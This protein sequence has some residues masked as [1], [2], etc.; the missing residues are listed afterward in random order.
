[1]PALQFFS[2]EADDAKW[3]IWGKIL[4]RKGTRGTRYPEPYVRVQITETAIRVS[5]DLQTFYYAGAISSACQCRTLS[6]VGPESDGTT[7]VV[8]SDGTVLASIVGQTGAGLANIN[9]PA[10]TTWTGDGWVQLFDSPPSEAYWTTGERLTFEVPADVCRPALPDQA[11]AYPGS[12]ERIGYTY[13]PAE[14]HTADYTTFDIRQYAN[15]ED[16]EDWTLVASGV[17][18]REVSIVFIDGVQHQR[19]VLTYT[20]CPL[21]LNDD[22]LDGPTTDVY[23]GYI[24]YIDAAI[25]ENT[26][27]ATP[28]TLAVSGSYT[29]GE[30]D[31][32]G[33]VQWALDWDAARV[34]ANLRERA[35]LKACS[36]A[37]TTAMLE[38]GVLSSV[39]T[40]MHDA[41]PVAFRPVEEFTEAEMREFTIIAFG[42]ASMAE[43]LSALEYGSESE[44]LA[45]YSVATF[46]ALYLQE[47]GSGV[48]RETFKGGESIA[49]F[50]LSIVHSVFGDLGMF[51]QVSDLADASLL[52]FHAVT[53]AVYSYNVQTAVWSGRGVVIADAEGNSAPISVPYQVGVNLVFRSRVRPWPELR[54]P[55][56]N[57]VLDPATYDGQK[58]DMALNPGSY[59]LFTPLLTA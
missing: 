53:K 22:Q 23:D 6:I 31:S 13:Y 36:D 11:P 16:P 20:H 37:T 34:V 40:V 26:T 12:I 51:P 44:F 33:A 10:V 58:A 39:L 28:V 18:T 21:V 8:L 41:H 4:H 38:D 48:P 15:P 2:P 47:V 17:R 30:A 49:V 19:T 46:A 14:I 57:G 59:P 32:A 27:V 50:A 42:Y 56:T 43:L 1:M 5:R 54:G 9:Y 35:R 29:Y 55:N 25:V 52:S 3:L 45:D 7:R 24:V